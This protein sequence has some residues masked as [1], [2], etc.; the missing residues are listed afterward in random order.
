MT[1]KA[2]VLL[3][4]DIDEAE[5]LKIRLVFHN[6]MILRELDGTAVSIKTQSAS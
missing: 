1:A 5:L 4:G 6:Y 2:A 3:S